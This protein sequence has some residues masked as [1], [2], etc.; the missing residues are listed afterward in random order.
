MH[1]YEWMVGALRCKRVDDG[2]FTFYV[3]GS[4]LVDRL[5]ITDPREWE[6]APLDATRVVSTGILVRQSGSYVPLVEAGLLCYGM[7]ITKDDIVRLLDLLKIETPRSQ[8]KHRLLKILAWFVKNDWNFVEE[9]VKDREE[10][11]VVDQLAEDPTFGAAFE[12]LD[13]NDKHEFGDIKKKL[14]EIT[15]RRLGRDLNVKK[16]IQEKR[17]KIARGRR[18]RP[19]LEPAAPDPPAPL[20]L[21]RPRLEGPKRN[22]KE[23][24]DNRGFFILAKV[25]SKNKLKAQTVVRNLPGHIDCNKS[26][27]LGVNFTLGEA[28]RLIMQW[29]IDGIASPDRVAHMK[30]KPPIHYS[31]SDIA[32]EADLLNTVHTSLADIPSEAGGGS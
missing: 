4:G 5:F 3:D 24:W 29:C 18:V 32:S 10:I 14:K 2:L 28:R 26:V 11:E 15:D 25:Y 13:P 9:A 12:D 22:L 8:A 23:P 6:I 17:R 30:I 31:L 27:T 1:N 21:A 7:K 20:P 16:R 19:R